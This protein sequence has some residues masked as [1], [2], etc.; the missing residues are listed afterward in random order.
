MKITKK[1]IKDLGGISIPYA[2]G[3]GCVFSVRG[4]DLSIIDIEMPKDVSSLVHKLLE[5]AYEQGKNMG[6]KDLELEF[7]DLLGL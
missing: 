1:L 4:H 3:G 5:R 2:E 7:R 6:R